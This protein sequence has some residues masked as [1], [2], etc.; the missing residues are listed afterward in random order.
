MIKSNKLK[1]PA[2]EKKTFSL[3]EAKLYITALILLFHVFPLVLKAVTPAAD[4]LLLN[5]VMLIVNPMIIAIVMLIYGIKQGFNKK[6]PI[7]CILL[8][9]I[10]VPMYYDI[11]VDPS[12]GLLYYYLISTSVALIEYA[13]FTFASI[14]IGS[15]IKESFL[16]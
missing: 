9:T 5:Y 1:Q 16:R 4:V 13:I 14:F 8:A 3:E 7:I 6:M 10:S 12:M 2:K 11:E 15:L